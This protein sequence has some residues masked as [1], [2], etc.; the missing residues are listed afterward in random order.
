MA[1]ASIDRR[2]RPALNANVRRCS[3]VFNVNI[4]TRLVHRSRV[5]ISARASPTGNRRT[6]ASVPTA[7]RANTVKSSCKCV[8]VIRATMAARVPNQHLS[9]TYASVLGLSMVSTVS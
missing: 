4:R 8:E 5:K 7:S 6:L 2:N 9:I 3:P 1:L